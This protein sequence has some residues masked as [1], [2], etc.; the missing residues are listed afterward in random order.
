LCPRQKILL[1]E[2]WFLQAG[3]G[4]ENT[5][6][7]SRQCFMVVA[8]AL[9]LGHNFFFF[10]TCFCDMELGYLPDTLSVSWKKVK[11]KCRCF[12]KHNVALF[13]FSTFSCDTGWVSVRYPLCIME[14]S[15]KKGRCF[16]K[17]M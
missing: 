14:K 4:A 12:E 7:K 17:I 3:K 15:V 8:R 2:N 13:I 11:K 5:K 1:A 6:E 9:L 16:K 10:F